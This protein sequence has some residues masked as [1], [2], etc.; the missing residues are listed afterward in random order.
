MIDIK[1]IRENRELVQKVVNDKRL[2]DVVD[3]QLLLDTDSDYSATLQ[4]VE[5]HRALRNQLSSN[6]SK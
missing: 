6:I 1:Y 3:L 4:K 2:G 5:S